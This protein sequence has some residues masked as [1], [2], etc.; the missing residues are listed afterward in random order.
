M[1]MLEQEKAF[2]YTLEELI[3]LHSQEQERTPL[4]LK[5]VEED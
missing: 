4:V 3:Q 5:D 2:F 1:I